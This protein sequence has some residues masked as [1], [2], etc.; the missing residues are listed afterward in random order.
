MIIIRI[1]KSRR[2]VLVRHAAGIGNMRNVCKILVGKREGK[3]YLQD[4]GVDG[5]MMLKWILNKQDRGVWTG[6][7]WLRIGTSGGP[8]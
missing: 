2:M 1:I 3:S 7:I 8:L 6:F 4:T 5:S